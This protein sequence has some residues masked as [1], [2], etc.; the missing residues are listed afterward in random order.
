MPIDDDSPQALSN[1]TRRRTPAPGFGLP[2]LLD[3]E[4]DEE[5][6]M[7]PKKL[8]FNDD[9]DEDEEDEMEQP[10]AL[11]GRPAASAGINT[12]RITVAPKLNLQPSLNSVQAQEDEGVDDFSDQEREILSVFFALLVKG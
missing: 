5:D 6:E 8:S 7:V 10:R 1:L 12:P 9:E 11:N 3:D 2:S 4:E